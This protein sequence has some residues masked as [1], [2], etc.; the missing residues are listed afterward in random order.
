MEHEPGCPK[1]Q[2]WDGGEWEV[3][4]RCRHRAARSRAFSIDAALAKVR[5]RH[6]D[7]RTEVADVYDLGDTTLVVQAA[8]RAGLYRKLGRSCAQVAAEVTEAA[9]TYEDWGWTDV[10]GFLASRNLGGQLSKPSAELWFYCP[11]CG[12]K[13]ALHDSLLGDCVM[14]SPHLPVL[15]CP[16]C[17][18]KYRLG[19]Y[20]LD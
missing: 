13:S 3:S 8:Q 10:A 7:V 12:E 4:C 19:L 1:A 20:P 9:A 14:A 17:H 11:C 5:G 2:F 16:H 6:P 15:F 18:M